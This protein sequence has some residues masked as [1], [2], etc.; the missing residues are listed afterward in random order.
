M[1]QIKSFEKNF[2][3]AS[4]SNQSKHESKKFEIFDDNE[5]QSK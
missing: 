3:E 5:K 1:E 4:V 2:A